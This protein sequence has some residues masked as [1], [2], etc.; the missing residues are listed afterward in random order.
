M[1]LKIA[2]LHLRRYCEDKFNIFDGIV[3]ILSSIEIILFYSG[4]AG[5]GG[6]VIIVF[7]AFRLLRIFKLAK[8]WTE[9]RKLM[10]N[11]FK[12]LQDVAYFSVLLLLFIF[13]YALIGMELYAYKLRFSGDEVDL[14]DGISPRE[15]FDDFLHAFVSVFIVLVGDDW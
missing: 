11:S 15:N 2:A 1:V 5:D 3:V 14:E 8:K 10:I 9:L 13:I 7:R 4:V 12:C 6:S